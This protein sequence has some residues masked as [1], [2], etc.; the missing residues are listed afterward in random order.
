M[1][2]LFVAAF[3]L[4]LV[5]SSNAQKEEKV[6][7]LG[8]SFSNLDDFN[9]VYRFGNSEALWRFSALNARLNYQPSDDN[10]ESLNAGFGLRFGREWRKPLSPKFKLRYGADLSAALSYA[11]SNFNEDSYSKST[12]YRGGLVGVF[13]FNFEIGRG[14]IFGA[15][16]L[17][18]LNY[19]GSQTKRKVDSSNTEEVSSN[20]QLGFNLNN[21][22]EL[23]LVYQF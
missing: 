10:R 15:E 19:T 8:F 16:L 22:L 11:N 20:S 6:R 14:L 2:N 21:S 13:G 5:F 23:S 3:V 17:P 12:G 9:L 1:K 18:S 7:E 4:G